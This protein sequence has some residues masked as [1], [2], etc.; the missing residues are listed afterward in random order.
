MIRFQSPTLTLKLHVLKRVIFEIDTTP[1]VHFTSTLTRET[2]AV[3]RLGRCE[4]RA[5]SSTNGK[6]S[7]P[8]NTVLRRT[9]N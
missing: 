4:L 3:V 9:G 8:K 6:L 1:D 5:Q 2:G 7:V